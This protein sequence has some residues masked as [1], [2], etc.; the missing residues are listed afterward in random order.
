VGNVWSNLIHKL[1]D[2]QLN[3]NNFIQNSMFDHA[4]GHVPELSDD[5]AWDVLSKSHM[6]KNGMLQQ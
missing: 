6:G 5:V 1:G 3:N 4:R 2:N